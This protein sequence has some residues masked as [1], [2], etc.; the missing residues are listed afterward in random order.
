MRNER[1]NESECEKLTGREWERERM[2]ECERS[3]IKRLDSRE[4]DQDNQI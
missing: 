2:K 1:Q 3:Q 4:K